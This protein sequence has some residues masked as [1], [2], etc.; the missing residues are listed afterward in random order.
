[1]AC[2]YSGKHKKKPTVVVTILIVMQKFI[3]STHTMTV[4]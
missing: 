2:Y 4:K 3:M 1:M